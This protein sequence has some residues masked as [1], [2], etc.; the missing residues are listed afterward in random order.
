[1]KALIFLSTCTGA[2][3]QAQPGI[4]LRGLFQFTPS[5][6]GTVSNL[7][8]AVR[9]VPGHQGDPNAGQPF[10]IPDATIPPGL[11]TGILAGVAP[12]LKVGRFVFRAGGLFGLT[13]FPQ[14]RKDSSGN[15]RELNQYG[16]TARGVG[17]SLVYYAVVP[18]AKPLSGL[19]AESEIR[20]SK[21]VGVIVGY[22]RTKYDLSVATGWDRYDALQ[23]YMDYTLAES[24]MQSFYGGLRI[25][26]PRL[27]VLV[28]GGAAL[29]GSSRTPIGAAANLVYP[30]STGVISVAIS[31]QLGRK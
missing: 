1:V 7:P 5:A 2:T 11:F 30:R 16:T 13:S 28:L 8:A 29:H 27:G 12:Q 23:P 26:P 14:P 21:S 10:L 3:A 20:A 17:T 19:Y 31:S 15:T 9:T 4:E 18:S 24:T 25:G 22:S 6:L